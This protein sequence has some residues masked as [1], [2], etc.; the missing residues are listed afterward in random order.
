[1]KLHLA[2]ERG[3]VAPCTK[4]APEVRQA[5]LGSL[6]EYA[7]KAK[8]KKGDF[9]EENPY[10]RSVNDFDGDDIQEIPPPRAKGVSINMAGASASKGKRKATIGINAYFKGRR[11]ISLPTIKACL[12]SKE[13]WQNT[14]MAIALWFYDAC[15]PINAVNSPFY[16]RAIDHIAS[17]GHGYK[18]LASTV[19][20]LMYN[21][22]FTL[23]WLRKSK[24]W[25][26]II[27]PGETRFATT[28]IALKSLYDRKENLQ[29]LV[30]SGDYKKIL[31][32]AKGKEAKQIV[33]ND[34]FWNNSLIL[35]RIMGP[36]IRLL[37]VCDADEKPSTGYVYEGIQR[38]IEE[39]TNGLL[40]YIET[41]VDWCD[42]AKFTHEIAMFR[43]REGSFGRK[44]ALNTS[45]TDRPEFWVVE[46]EP[47]GELDYEELEAE[48]EELP[49]DDDVEYNDNDDKIEQD[50]DLESF[51]RSGISLIDEDDEWLN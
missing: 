3:S 51:Q 41:Y 14:D 23:N 29:A 28:F 17:M 22:K 48:L 20:V 5:I 9:G 13:K 35:V 19:T 11:D 33:L 4:I 8:E 18:D 6:K 39:V 27:H 37:R 24:G 15:I 32:M 47:V 10:G 30:T 44:L 31:K 34:K 12:Q 45:R 50:V 36:L 49:V 21:H 25:K 46:E 40:D 16:Q 7:Q 43:E 1:M 42:H 26:E 2:G 38:A